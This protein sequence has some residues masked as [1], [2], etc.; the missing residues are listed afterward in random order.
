MTANKKRLYIALYPSG[1]VGNEERRYHWAF[2]IGPKVEKGKEVPGA[3]YHVKNSPVGGCV[4]EEKDVLDVRLTNTLLGRILIAKV[5]N[6]QRLVNILRNLP[7]VNGD[8][9]WR[10]R[11]WVKTL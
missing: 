5:E 6:E 7:V 11:T 3:R 1:V 9:N 10:C 4:Y 2:L 8:P